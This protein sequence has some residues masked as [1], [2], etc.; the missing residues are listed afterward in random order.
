MDHAEMLRVADTIPFHFARR[1]ATIECVRACL[2]ENGSPS[3][4]WPLRNAC[5]RLGE[6]AKEKSIARDL[7]HAMSRAPAMEETWRRDELLCLFQLHVS[8]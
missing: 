1:F 6:A 5:A 2:C 8:S 7:E 4:S 3:L